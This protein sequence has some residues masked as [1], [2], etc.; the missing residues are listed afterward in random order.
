MK[1]NI[2]EKKLILYLMLTVSILASLSL[3][4]QISKF[5]LGHARLFGFVYFFNFGSEANLPTIFNVFLLLFTSIIIFLI[6]LNIKTNIIIRKYWLGLFFLF[7]YL[8]ADE[9]WVIHERLT[10]SLRDL[11]NFKYAFFITAPFLILPVVLIFIRFLFLIPKN[12]IKWI[13]IAATIY[14]LGAAGFEI[15]S[16]LYKKA[17]GGGFI[18]EIISTFEESIELL[19]I[20]IFI[21]FLLKYIKSELKNI[22][23]LMIVE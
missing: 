6:F 7:L 2:S 11:I 21:K 14:L 13:I 8:G 5:F 16:M 20:I 4:G 10:T 3:L 19:G 1:Y 23:F 22:S 18:L 12:L 9:G 15:I 17:Y